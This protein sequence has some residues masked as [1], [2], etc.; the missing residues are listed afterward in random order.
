[1][2]GYQQTLTSPALQKIQHVSLAGLDFY[3]FLLVCRV[4]A[5]IFVRKLST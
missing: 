2:Q 4:P 1:M 5:Y 3:F